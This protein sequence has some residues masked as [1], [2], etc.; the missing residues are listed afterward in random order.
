LREAGLTHGVK[1]WL[2][3]YLLHK[4]RLWDYRTANGVDYFIANSQ[5]I[6]RRIHKV[7]RREATVIHPPVAT[8]KFTPVYTKGD[9]YFTA[10]RLVPY[11]QVALIAE[12]FAQMP[13][14]KLII[15]GSGPD[16]AKV[17]KIVERAP[18][19]QFL[20][21][22][23]DATM[24]NYLQTARA[25]VF[26]ALEDFGIMPLEAQACATPVIAYGNGGVCDSLYGLDAD[27]S[28]AVFFKQQT[29]QAL[30]NAIDEF[31]ATTK[32]DLKHCELNAQRFS[33][34]NFCRQFTDFVV[35]KY[36][37]FKAGH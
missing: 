7:Y 10:S 24:I 26:A 15:A 1:S 9:F 19:I 22:I 29:T 12:A 30:I 20:G 5:F 17:Q 31:E 13:Q 25:F 28:T 6:A 18:N 23:D 14:R 4:I 21:Y 35:E 2:T 3:R 34:E 36:Q 32:I 8:H 16:E 11:K 37:E 33:N 27:T